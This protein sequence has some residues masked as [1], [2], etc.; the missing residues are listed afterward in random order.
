M[1]NFFS[2]TKVLVQFIFLFSLLVG[3]CGVNAD[4]KETKVIEVSGKGMVY[5]KPDRA[6]VVVLV[7]QMSRVAEKAKAV[8][9]GDTKQITQFLL[10]QNIDETA[11]DTSSYNI[12]PQYNYKEGKD[13]IGYRVSRKISFTLNDTGSLFKVIDGLTRRGASQI[14][15]Q[16][17]YYSQ[18]DKAYEKALELAFSDAKK[19]AGIIAKKS[20]ASIL[21]V[22][23]VIE[24][25]QAQ[26]IMM[27]DVQAFKSAE[28]MQV[29]LRPVEASLRIR[30]E[31]K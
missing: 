17:L 11:L 2:R 30:F 1:N 25:S 14:L 12:Y 13:L 6:S 20:N 24:M 16:N 26:G 4:T 22:H 21:G 7:E 31:I 9:D 3:T 19:K 29:A 23:N 27:A 8:V 18:A 28:S 5:N 10:N 15:Q